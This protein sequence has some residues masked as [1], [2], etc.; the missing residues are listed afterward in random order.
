MNDPT[1]ESSE[2]INAY[3]QCAEVTLPSKYWSNALVFLKHTEKS[4][5]QTKY[6]Q[7]VAKDIQLGTQCQ[8][9]QNKYRDSFKFKMTPNQSVADSYVI[10]QV[11]QFCPSQLHFEGGNARECLRFNDGM[12][13]CYKDSLSSPSSEALK[14]YKQCATNL[15]SLSWKM[16]QPYGMSN[17]YAP[18]M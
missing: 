1:N 12:S 3:K 6:D 15:P 10:D 2:A 7:Y 4:T 8:N 13:F 16:P 18:N 5:F 9:I 14:A 11:N 17:G